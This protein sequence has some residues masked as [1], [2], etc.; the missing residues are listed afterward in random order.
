MR[1]HGK[2][3]WS[4]PATG[5]RVSMDFMTIVRTLIALVSIVSAG[6]S[7]ACRTDSN[8]TPLIHQV[9]PV[10]E[11]GEIAARVEIVSNDLDQRLTI[12]ARI[13]DRLRG[14]FDQNTILLRPTIISSCDGIPSIGDTGIVV[15]RI[16]EASATALVVDPRRG[17]TDRERRLWDSLSMPPAN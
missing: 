12:E 4:A 13:L 8:R 11:D 2:P 5:I 14:D 3:V 1:G 10:L 16:L 15:G 7:L 17:P 9:L 6:P